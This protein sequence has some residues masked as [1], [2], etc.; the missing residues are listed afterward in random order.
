V[1]AGYRPQFFLPEFFDF[2]ARQLNANHRVGRIALST[3]A[4]VAEELHSAGT[5]EPRTVAGFVSKFNNPN[6]RSNL[7]WSTQHVS[8]DVL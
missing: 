2:A 4:I 1:A 7:E 5:S 8:V 6:L 3:A